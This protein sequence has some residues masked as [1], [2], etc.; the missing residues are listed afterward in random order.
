MKIR[1]IILGFAF[2][3]LVSC[4]DDKPKG[5]AQPAAQEVKNED[6]LKVSFD[7]IVKKDDNMHLYYTQDETINFDE[8]NSLWVP[9]KGSDNVQELTFNLPKDV[10]PTHLRVDLGYGKNEQ[11][12]DIELK[13][14]RMKYGEKTF[15]V[16]DTIIFNYF[17]PN[18]DNT[19]VVPKT[20]ILKRK[21]KDQ[22]SGPMLYPHE[23][24]T[25]QLKLIV[26]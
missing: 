18:K 4:K 19:V 20:A 21:S 7:L 3:S 6:F 12:S 11:Q 9:V 13:S 16:K 15:E 24:L 22:G 14:F 17:Y 1:L 23:P 2:L 25:N 8:K 10:F 5:E 26:Q